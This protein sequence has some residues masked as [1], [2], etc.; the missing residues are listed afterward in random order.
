M[1]ASL[2]L[3]AV[4][5]NSLIA[6]REHMTVEDQY[7][8]VC[9]TAEHIADLVEA[10]Y[11]VVVTHGNGPQ[12]GFILRRSEIAREVAHMH[13]VP[14]VSCDADTQGAIGYQ[15]Q[16]A[17]DNEF[18]K[19]NIGLTAA[20]IVTQILVDPEDEAFRKPAKPIGEFYNTDE[21]ELLKSAYPDWTLV[22]D[23]GRGFRRVVASP[24]PR[25]IIELDAI[26][27][28]LKS[29]FC[30]IAA[31][32]GGIPVVESEDGILEGRDA[33]IDKDFAS[34]FLSYE[35]GADVFIISTGVK[36]VCLNFGKPDQKSLNRITA[37]EAKEYLDAGHFAPG[38]M[39]PK[40]QAALDF[41]GRGG[42]EVV[43]TSPE[44]LKEAVLNG[45]G[46]HITAN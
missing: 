46:T 30:V 23:A 33:V 18:R 31:G 36:E 34:A 44:N 27:A 2:A 11:R 45:K 1:S 26:K 40:I 4:G 39:A 38:S 10:G 20:T 42:K 29:D 43:I 5:G 16:Q 41:L 14:L 32:G 19:R 8:A 25:K 24:L 15:I 13:P 3:I 22:E 21:A 6:D 9:E 7:K 12:V 17:L 37:A 28:L 35:I